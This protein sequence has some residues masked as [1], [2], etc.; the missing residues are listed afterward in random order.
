MTARCCALALAL[1]AGC[2]S[3][4]AD[5]EPPGPIDAAVPRPAACVQ[6]DD[7][8]MAA[9][10]TLHEAGF[11]PTHAVAVRVPACG[12]RT[13]AVTSDTELAVPAEQRSYEIGSIT[14]TFV[15]SALLELWQAGKVDLDAQVSSLL[16]TLPGMSTTTIRQLLNH[17]SGLYNY[18]DDPAII[19]YLEQHFEPEALVQVA[20]GHEPYFAP[21]AG[22]HYSNTNYI[23]AGLIIEHLSGKSAASYIRETFL[24]PHGI[25]SVYLVGDEPAIGTLAPGHDRD[26]D[27]VST[28]SDLSGAWT[29][30]AMVGQLEDVARWTELRGDGSL[31]AAPA[32]AALLDTV[33]TTSAGL[34]YG[35]GIFEF[36]PSITGGLGKGLGHGG[37]IPGYHTQAFYFPERGTSLAAAVTSDRDR[38]NDV[39]VALLPIIERATQ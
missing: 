8:I 24:V 29:A 39:T 13:Y 14:K 31:H 25:A 18:T 35:L 9:L 21:G 17:T 6:L 26:G 33:A 16:P 4:P 7:E 3:A 37:D 27:P 30:G 12:A 32:Q 5:T 36:A 2:A 15:A 10:T 19:P 28:T 34:R 38:A 20:A 22:W 23:V 1:L 11:G